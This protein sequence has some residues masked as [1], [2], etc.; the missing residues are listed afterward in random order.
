MLTDSS[1]CTSAEVALQIYVMSLSGG[2]AL[3]Q[4]SSTGLVIGFFAACIPRGGS[5]KSRSPVKYEIPKR[6]SVGRTLVSLNIPGHL[7]NIMASIYN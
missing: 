7:G 3:A 1:L 6:R 4:C 2:A 5:L